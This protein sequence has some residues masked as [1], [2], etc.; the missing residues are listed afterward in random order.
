[1]EI[2]STIIHVV[3][4]TIEYIGL[5]VVVISAIIALVHT[6][7]RK[8]DIIK[9][10]SDFAQNV[11]FGLEFIIAADILLVTIAHN[12]DEIL[13]LGGIVIIRILLGYTLRKEMIGGKK[14]RFNFFGKK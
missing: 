13:K 4:L 6:V 9:I 7:V 2:F 1:M 8:H 12:N 10:R 14:K 5:A 11:M 3:G